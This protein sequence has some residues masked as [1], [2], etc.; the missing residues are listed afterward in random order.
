MNAILIFKTVGIERG[1]S[2][3]S[4]TYNMLIKIL[5]DDFGVVIFNEEN[6]DFAITDYIIDSISFMQFVISIEESIHKNLPDDFLDYN[7]L[8]SIKGFAEKLD[9]FLE[10]S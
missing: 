1:E 4:C 8:S 5:M 6:E 7:L 10:S 9:C 3:M 2:S